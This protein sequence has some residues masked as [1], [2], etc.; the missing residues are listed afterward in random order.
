MMTGWRAQRLIYALHKGPVPH[1]RLW[2]PQERAASHGHAS[3]TL[4]PVLSGNNPIDHIFQFHKVRSGNS[5]T[6]GAQ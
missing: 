3:S 5:T 6:F 4:L 2:P 1:L